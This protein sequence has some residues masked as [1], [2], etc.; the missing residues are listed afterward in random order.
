MTPAN[1]KRPRKRRSSRADIVHGDESP[2]K[3]LPLPPPFAPPG[4]EGRAPAPLTIF[5]LG[6]SNHDPEA[7]LALVRQ[8]HLQTV[9]DVRSVP[10]SRYAPHFNQDALG[11]L[12][13]EARVRYVW[14][15]DTLGG[16]PADPTC[17]FDDRMRVGNVNYAAMAE[18]AWYQEGVRRL[19]EIAAHGP[20]ALLCSEEEPRRCHRHRLIEATLR[21]RGVV[22]WH[23][24]KD[25]ALESIAP[26]EEAMPDAP[27]PQLALRGF[28]P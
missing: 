19:L 28:A 10:Y 18:K 2:V 20:T 26:D 15:G 14:S 17:Y 22:V 25:G 13:D 23:I 24:R 12:L 6:H 4:D 21:D 7:F 27:S 1:G 9:V 11:R 8:H 3:Q 16:R 5:T